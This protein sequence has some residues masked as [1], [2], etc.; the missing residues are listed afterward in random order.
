MTQ[1]NV[2]NLKR[3][4]DGA[5]YVELG[6]YPSGVISDVQVAIEELIEDRAKLVEA[7]GS[8]CSWCDDQLGVGAGTIN[9]YEHARV[10]LKELEGE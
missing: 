7:L 4:V 10:V 5:D 1:E 6:T 2:D 9:E 8:L 3:D